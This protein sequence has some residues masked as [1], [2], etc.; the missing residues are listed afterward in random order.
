MVG[1]L[2]FNRGAYEQSLPGLQ[3]TIDRHRKT[4]FAENAAW[5]LALAHHFLG[6]PE[7]ALTALAEYARL[8]G[9]DAEATRRV[10]YWRGRF[11][12]AKGSAEEGLNLWRGLVKEEPFSYYGLLAAARLRERRQKVK[13]ELPRPDFKLAPIARKTAA[14]PALQRAEELARAGLTVE[15]GVEARTAARAH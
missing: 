15:A 11:L 13:L 10:A 8:A 9:S 12:V 7:P 1:W 6:H 14:D 3:A 2:E 4:T 5:Y